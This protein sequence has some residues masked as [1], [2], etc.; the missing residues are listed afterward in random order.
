M[1]STTPSLGWRLFGNCDIPDLTLF[2][3]RYP[4]LRSMRFGRR[5]RA[6]AAPSRNQGAGRAGSPWHHPVARPH[7]SFL[8][9]LGFLFD[10]LGSGRSGFQ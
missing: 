7:A 8:L 5:A 9:R 4:T 6:E 3:A 1:P 2:P 10:R